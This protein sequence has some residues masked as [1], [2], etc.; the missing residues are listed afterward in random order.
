MNLY[1]KEDMVYML[2]NDMDDQCKIK[3][4]DCNDAAFVDVN[5]FVSASNFFSPYLYCRLYY[6]TI[7]HDHINIDNVYYRVLLVFNKTKITEIQS[8]ITSLPKL[9]QN[10]GDYEFYIRDKKLNEIIK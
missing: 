9:M 2:I 1:S 3:F 6:S 7:I 8:N 4:V 5:F 10:I